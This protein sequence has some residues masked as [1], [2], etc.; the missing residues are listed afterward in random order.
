MI[1]TYESKLPRIYAYITPGISYHEG[2][3]KIG[4]TVTQTVD[5]RIKQQTHTAWIIYEKVWELRAPYD[6]ILDR[7]LT[8]KDFH[9]FLIGRYKI[10]RAADDLEWFKIDGETARKCFKEFCAGKTF[11]EPPPVESESYSLRDEQITAVNQTV[12]YWLSDAESRKYLWNAKPRFGKNLAV[13]EFI[14]EY[15]AAKVLIVTNRPAVANSWYADFKKFAAQNPDGNYTFAANTALKGQVQPFDGD[16]S[17]NQRL[18]AF[19]SLQDLKGADLGGEIKKL[20]WIKNFRWDILVVDESHEGV[21]TAKTAEA[22]EYIARE[23][24]LYLSGTPFKAIANQDFKTAQIYNWSYYDEQRAKRNFT[25]EP[26]PYADLPRMNLFCYTIS[27]MIAKKISAGTIID[28]ENVDYTFDLNEFFRTEK[29]TFKHEDDVKKFLD[30]LT[31]NENFPFSTPE[32]RN[33]LKHTFWLMFRV[34]DAKAMAKLLKAHAVFGEYEII[35]AAG[36]GKLDE[37][38]ENLN[39]KSFKRVTEA[40][41][42][43]KKT[44]TLSVGQLTTGVTVPEWTAVL[45]L[46]DTKSATQYIQAA[47]RAQNP[48]IV[49]AVHKT[50]CY[51][52]DFKPARAL[53]IYTE[54]AGNIGSGNSASK[55]IADLLNFFPVLAEDSAGKMSPLNAENIMSLPQT[56]KIN[57]VIDSGFMSNLIFNGE[58]IFHVFSAPKSVEKIIN[59]LHRDE[60]PPDKNIRVKI[61]IDKP[62]APKPIKNILI[63]KKT[64]PREEI[65]PSEITKEI[66]DAVKDEYRLTKAQADSIARKIDKQIVDDTSAENIA[67]VQR[68]VVE[69]L[70]AKRANDAKRQ[71]ENEIRARLR[72]FARTIPSFIMAYG[73]RALTLE[74]F[75]TYI[76]AATFEEVTGITLEDFIFLRDGGDR[77]GEHFDGGLFNSKVFNGAIQEFLNRREALGDYFVEGRD[78]DIFTY[79][80]PQNTR[81]IFTPRPVVIEMAD[82]LA[83]QNPGVFDNPDQQFFDPYMKS[84]MFIV[85]IVKRLYRSPA[86]K[87]IFPDD[88]DRLRHILENQV[89][90]FAPTE[91]IRRIA[92]NYIFGNRNDISRRNF[93]CA[94]ISRIIQAGELDDFIKKNLTV[95]V[96]I[97][98]TERVKKYGEVFTPPEIVNE[99]LDNPL[100]ADVFEDLDAKILEPTAGKGAFLVGILQR[101]LA[102]AHSPRDM[103]RALASIYAV[104]LQ[105]DNLDAAKAAMADIFIAH[106]KNISPAEKI[107]MRRIIDANIVQGDILAKK[108]YHDEEISFVDWSTDNLTPRLSFSYTSLTEGDRIQYLDVKLAIAIGNPP[109]QLDTKGDNKTYAPPIYHRFLEEF[110][111]LCSRVMMIHP[112]RCLFQ[113]GGTPKAFIKKFLSDEHIT[114]IRYEPDCKKIFKNLDIKGGVAISYRDANK[115]FGAIGTFIPFK[116]L[117]SIFLKVTS[118]SDFKPLSE[119]MRGQMI[120]KLSAKAYA[121]FPDLPARLPKRADTA[122][123]TN[124]FELLPDIFLEEKP[125]D[126]N[127]YFQIE[128]LHKT[129][130]TSRFVRQIYMIDIP[131]F[132]TYKTFIPAAYGSGA[133]GEKGPTAL[134]GSPLVGATQ[135]F[136]TLGAFDSAAKATAAMKFVKTKFARALLG[137]LKVTQHNPPETWRFVPQQDFSAESDVPWEKSVAQIDEYL[138]EKYQLSAAEKQFI[139]A[140]VKEMT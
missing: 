82:A 19:V 46:N 93:I 40:I 67:R 91:I 111:S 88:N 62:D 35:V 75:H 38:D 53:E 130:R 37:N 140:N 16:I 128:G 21:D 118:R 22:F 51:V 59:R 109:Y 28:E 126:G 64:K 106:H 30:A 77:D 44:I 127:E 115:V 104:E 73:D 23:F 60:M 97:L 52:F 5:E 83:R 103:F 8:D 134:V 95:K 92:T 47:F 139:E 27:N 7:Q 20:N 110:Y 138:Y 49:G 9:R 39:K 36:D 14:K 1:E 123:R 136:I 102:H 133:L 121:D 69:V 80:P 85:E 3:L 135:T 90:G 6:E 114:V 54:F 108:N 18:I 74:N 34:E 120:F 45:M 94:D 116:E 124:V 89:F 98:N 86:L 87:K 112:A 32:L 105:L 117:K 25:G 26:N 132:H 41:A 56:I 137:I 107:I 70:E 66:V 122:I 48:H 84:G 99:M 119:I 12:D 125:N 57:Q 10:K 113:A 33:E 101:K 17:D 76:D 43:N 2:W 72:G 31:Q 71:T 79:I 100:I 4:Y 11:K 13:Y 29:G 24:T 42:S 129:K 15:G 81:Q 55:N 65:Q 63:D 58:K 61:Q 50:N 78:E 131:E 96:T 68:E